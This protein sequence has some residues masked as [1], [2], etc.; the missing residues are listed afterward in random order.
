MSQ[1]VII[2]D[3]L[4]P[5]QMITPECVGFKDKSEVPNTFISFHSMIKNQYN[6]SIKVFRTE[7]GT[8]FFSSVLSDFISQNSLS[9]HSSCIDS[10]KQNGILERKNRLLLEV[11]QLLLLAADVPNFFW[12]DAI[13]TVCYLINRQP[14]RS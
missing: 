11:A 8:E 1:L 10:P 12:G 14:S 7:N 4:S 9:H 13:L 3:G 6:T 2:N 5:L